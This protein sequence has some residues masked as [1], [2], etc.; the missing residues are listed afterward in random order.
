[1][2]M[3]TEASPYGLYAVDMTQKPCETCPHQSPIDFAARLCNTKKLTGLDAIKIGKSVDEDGH[4]IWARLTSESVLV[5]GWDTEAANQD[6][7]S[8]GY[9][10]L[11]E[12][13]IHDELEDCKA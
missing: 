3:R 1:M 13:S 7:G 12:L 4:S 11:S 5:T 6:P 10:K 2:G 9:W 8:A